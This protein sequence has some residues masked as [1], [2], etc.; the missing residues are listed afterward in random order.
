MPKEPTA[1]AIRSIKKYEK[2]KSVK[3]SPALQIY[4]SSVQDTK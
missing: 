1:S 4:D 2:A 3:V